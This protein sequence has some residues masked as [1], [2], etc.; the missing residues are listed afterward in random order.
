[1]FLKRILNRDDSDS[2]R[3]SGNPDLSGTSQEIR[4]VLKYSSNTDCVGVTPTTTGYSFA[5]E[6]KMVSKI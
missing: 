4:D 1:M 3:D 5:A 2:H 6:K